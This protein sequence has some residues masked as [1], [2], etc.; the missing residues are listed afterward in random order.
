MSEFKPSKRLVHKGV[1][2]AI[3]RYDSGDHT[4]NKGETWLYLG[5]AFV[6]DLADG[7]WPDLPIVACRHRVTREWWVTS[8]T[9]WHE[10]KEPFPDDVFCGSLRAALDYLV[11]E[12]VAKKLES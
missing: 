4:N 12:A 7:T 1:T 9:S 3:R 5:I 6:Q 8:D 11:V 10:G 2:F